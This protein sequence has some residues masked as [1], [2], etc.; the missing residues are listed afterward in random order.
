MTHENGA[1]KVK[2]DRVGQIEFITPI[3]H[4]Q[5]FFHCSGG[6]GSVCPDIFESRIKPL[7]MIHGIKEIRIDG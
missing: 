4:E 5:L 2:K 7:L 1:M 3:T 6:D